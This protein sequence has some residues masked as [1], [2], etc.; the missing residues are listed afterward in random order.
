MKKKIL[1]GIAACVLVFA[2]IGASV[3]A[4]TVKHTVVS[5]DTLWK[6]AVKYQVGLSEI[7]SA[8]PQFFQSSSDLSGTDGLRSAGG[9][10]RYFL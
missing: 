6:I 2:N 5:G 4:A 9:Q 10:Q 1:A 8:N 3:F 7:I